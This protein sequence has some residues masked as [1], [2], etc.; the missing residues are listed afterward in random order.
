MKLRH[1]SSP[2]F[3]ARMGIG[4]RIIPAFALRLSNPEVRPWR[5]INEDPRQWVAGDFGFST[6]ISRLAWHSTAGSKIATPA[7]SSFEA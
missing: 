4:L 5:A 6:T 2:Y 7:R 1:C 3:A